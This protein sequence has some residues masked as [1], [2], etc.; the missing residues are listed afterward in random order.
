MW[1]GPN[2]S[3]DIPEHW[4]TE[5]WFLPKAIALPIRETSYHLQMKEDQIVYISRVYDDGWDAPQPWPRRRRDVGESEWTAT[6]GGTG[7]I[8]EEADF[9]T[10]GEAIA[11]A[12]ERSDIILVR[13][14]SDPEGTYSAGTRAATWFI[15]GT[16]WPFPPWP[17][18]TWPDYS[19]PPEP[20]WPEFD[21]PDD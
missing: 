14:A 20:G 18:A 19:G 6:T 4:R 2:R 13:L 17:P 8:D 9:D 21:A 3:G 5:A 11:W 16:G 12:R 10:V 15:D 1:S 7:D